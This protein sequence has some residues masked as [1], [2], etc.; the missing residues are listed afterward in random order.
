MA[1]WSRFEKELDLETRRLI[2]HLS[3]IQDEEDQNF[4][5][6][7]KFTWSNF[8]FH[9]FLDVN[10]HNV[11]RSIN[12]IHE[13]LMVHSDLSK[14]E[15]W[16]RL[17]EEFLNSPLPNTDGIKT[18]VH[19][20]MVAL[21]LHLSDSPSNTNFCERPRLKETEKEDTFDWAKYLMEGEDI[22]TGPFPDTPEWSE[23]ESEEEDSQQPLSR[24]DSG[25]QVDKT[26]Q[27]DHEQNDKTVQVTWTMGEPDSRAWLEQHIVTSYW[28]P[29]SPRFPHSLHLHSNLY[30]V[31][32]Q[33]LYNTGP[34]YLPEEKSFVTETQVIRETLWLLSGVK[35]LFIFQHNDGKVTVRND[36]VVTHLTNNCLQSVLEHIAAYG[37]AVSRLQRFIDE[38]T[39]HSAEPCPPGHNPSASSKKSSEPPFR[40]YQAFVWALYKYFTTFKEELNTIE[41]DII[42]KGSSEDQTT[43]MLVTALKGLKVIDVACGSGDAQTLAVTENGQVWSWGDGDYGK[44]GRGGSDGC[45]TPKLVEKLQ[46]LDIVKVCC[47]SQFSVALNKD[48]QVYTWG[49]GDNQRLG[50]GTDEHVRYPK[51]LDSL[52]GKSVVDIA[53]GST[54]CLALTEEG[55]VHSWGSNDKLQHFDTLFSNKKQPKALPGLNSKHIVGISCGPGQ[56]FSWS[57]CSEWSVGLRV[58]FVVDVCTMTFEQLDQLLRQVCEGMDGSSDWPPQQ[59]KECMV[60]AALN[61]LRL[62]L[63]AAISNQ[64]DPEELGLGLGSGLL[65][66]LKQ[67]VVTLA[68][69]AGVLNTVQAAA[70]AVLQS[71]WSVIL[72]TAEE[73]ARA[74]SSLLPN[75][76][77]GNEMS[78]SPGRRFMIDLLVSSLMADGG[79]ES[80]LNAAITA[81]IQDI[82]AKKEAQK[83]KEIDEQEASASTLH[84]CR[85]TLDKDLINTGIYESANK[86]SLPLVQLVQQ[87]LRNIASQTIARL[88]DVARRISN[89]QDT[90]QVSKERSA[91]LDLL[92][93][94]QRLLVCKLYVG[95]NGTV[96]VGGYTLSHSEILGVGSLLK[97][98]MALLCT[99]IGDIL[100]VATSIAINSHRHFAEV[101][102][103]IEGDLTGVLLPELIVSIVLLLTHDAGL[104]QETGSIPLLAALL[105]HLDRFNHLAPGSERDD[106][107]DLA[108]PGLMSS[109]FNGP[110]TKNNEEVSL[111]RK[112]DLEN[113]NKD[114]GF[115]TVID[116]K[117][118]D[119]K[120]FQAQTLTGN[121]ILAQ[122]AGEDPVVALEAALQFEDTRESMQSFCVGQ[123][124]EPNQEM[125]TT[126]DLSSLSSPLIDAERNLGLLLGLHASYLAMSTPLS[127]IEIECAKWLQS[128][129]F[130]G[131][132]QTSQ[133]HYN[134]NEEKDEDQCSSPGTTTPDKSKLYSRRITLSDHA[135]PFLQAIADNNTQDHTVKDFLCQIERCCKQYHLITPITFP[136]EHPVE[137]VGRLLLCCL[138]K[139]QDLG[140]VALTLVD[141]FALVVDQGKQR[142][143]PKSV[144]DV[145]RMVYQAKCSLIKTHQEQ[146]RSYKEVCAPVIE[147]LRFLFNE[148]RPAHYQK[149]LFDEEGGLGRLRFS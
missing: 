97:K 103:V 44:L 124:I 82:E 111:I 141:Q 26:P 70:Q 36:V 75:A 109:F 106:N 31:W 80:A 5:M 134:Y 68:S 1:H 19:Y 34:L 54:H 121:S 37:Q 137:E 98:Y 18:D 92:L 61:L 126:P 64:V 62:Q 47:G 59:E 116:G 110:S 49:K 29:N 86:Q 104:M 33:H 142:S 14:A 138:L 51:L 112:A 89:S 78:I 3:G 93:R 10:G 95:V 143:L 20:S 6:A 55:E 74:L 52:Q 11:Q 66:N 17:T 21:L 128:S 50:H 83:E 39:G 129:I 57:S 115:W 88:K 63:H 76:V 147:R 81:E 40:T 69:N 145:C 146:G 15:S 84:R 130:F 41:R 100:P 38:V 85:T 101:A 7:L 71:G 53:V 16:K 139:H 148:L 120:D 79:L 132:L 35:K 127:R 42:G 135:Q 107:E 99:H 28:V 60:V 8:K 27:E 105:E 119:I 77:S 102:R 94:F 58:P 90:E 12:G 96:G 122:F 56:S 45:K 2:S 4:Q 24:E 43:P 140:P 32:D 136:P 114:G 13:K 149:S 113:H 67:T 48:G 131:G 22:D 117:V 91:S 118:Y 65:N 23:D 73:R 133:I 46:D 125:V 123:Y 25:I 72:P 30:N 108:W 9:R 87:L 144:I